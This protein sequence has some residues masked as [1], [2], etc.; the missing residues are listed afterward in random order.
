MIGGTIL[1]WGETV[2]ELAATYTLAKAGQGTMALAACFGCPIFN[3]LMGLGLPVLF[4]TGIAGTLPLLLTNG[5]FLLILQSVRFRPCLFSLTPPCLSPV[6]RLLWL[7]I[8]SNSR[9][10]LG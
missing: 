4:K 2:P 5:I 10:R 7:G 1:S 6:D 9:S 8:A 3:L